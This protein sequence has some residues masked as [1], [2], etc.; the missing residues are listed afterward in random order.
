MTVNAIIDASWGNGSDAPGWNWQ[1]LQQAFATA[2][3]AVM[4][5]VGNSQNYQNYSYTAIS[6]GNTGRVACLDPQFLDWGHYIPAAIRITAYDN[7]TGGAQVGRSHG[8]I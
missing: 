4:Q 3:W 8:H 1:D 7:D 6:G 5:A 2:L